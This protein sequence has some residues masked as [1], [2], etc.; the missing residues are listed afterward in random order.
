M[1]S[2]RK[3]LALILCDGFMAALLTGCSGGDGKR[4]IRIG[5]NQA[6]DHPTLV[7]LI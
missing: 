1:K 4:I 6:T 5:H 3:A 2:F 7:G